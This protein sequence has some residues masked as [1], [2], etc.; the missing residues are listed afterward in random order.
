MGL[1]CVETISSTWVLNC[2]HSKN[3]TLQRNFLRPSVFDLH[4]V[5]SNPLFE[6]LN[7]EG[8]HHETYKRLWDIPH[9]NFTINFNIR[10][11]KF[12]P[13]SLRL[14]YKLKPAHTIV[15]LRNYDPLKQSYLYDPESFSQKP[16]NNPRD[17]FISTDS[18][19]IELNCMQITVADPSLHL[20]KASD[21]TLND[22]ALKLF[23]APA[24]QHYS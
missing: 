23:I 12:S 24:S 15:S 2:K 21:R 14:F 1:L 5:D 3:F 16:L 7:K 13:F 20:S 9:P 4:T 18:A 8:V 22:K 17:C 11:R 6:S 19:H 10:T